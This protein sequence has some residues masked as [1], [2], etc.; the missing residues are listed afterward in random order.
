MQ[1]RVSFSLQPRMRLWALV[2]EEPP[3]KG[4]ERTNLERGLVPTRVSFTNEIGHMV[5]SETTMVRTG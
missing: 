2:E 1:V 4:K 3:M 5:P